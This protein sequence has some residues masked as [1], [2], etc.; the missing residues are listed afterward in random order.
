MQL[1]AKL[2]LAVAFV[3]LAAACEEEQRSDAR[4]S[5]GGSAKV[6]TQTVRRQSIVDEIEALGTARANESIEIRPRIAS[7]V[8]RVAFDEGQRV[9]AG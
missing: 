2:G 1:P 5:W 8:E 3:L 7:L 6:V 9:D 4:G